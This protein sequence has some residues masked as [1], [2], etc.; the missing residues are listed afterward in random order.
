MALS[1]SRTCRAIRDNR[2]TWIVSSSMLTEMGTLTCW[3][4]AATDIF[5]E[6][7]EEYIPRLYV[8]DGKGNFTLDR[9]AIP[10]TVKTSAGCHQHRRFQRRRATGYFSWWPRRQTIPA[11]TPKFFVAERPRPFHR[12]HRCCL[13][14]D[15][16][17]GNGHS[18]PMGGL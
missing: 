10:A 6:D 3:S 4:A 9:S 15:K 2:R 5:T 13:P 11:V 12:R 14:C 18:R 17:G 8:N 7:A 1:N 16:P